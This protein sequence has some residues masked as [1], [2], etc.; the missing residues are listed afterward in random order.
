VP[1]TISFV[2]PN[3]AGGDAVAEI[4]SAFFELVG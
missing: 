2:R 3:A 4:V 1:V